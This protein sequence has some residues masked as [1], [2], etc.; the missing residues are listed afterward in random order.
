MFHTFKK[1]W[2]PYITAG[3]G[4]AFNNAYAYIETPIISSDVPMTEPF[5]SHSTKA[6][7][8][9]AG[10]GLDVDVGEHLRAG[11]G[12]RF[13][14]LGQASLGMTPLQD[15]TNTISH[16]HLHANEFLAQLTFVG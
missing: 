7:T 14:D 3:V 1:I 10:L 13:L 9:F 6:F 11:A 15:S 12:Y 16:S 5:S 8:Y 4:E 2:H